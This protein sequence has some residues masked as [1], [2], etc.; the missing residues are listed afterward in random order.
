MAYPKVGPASLEHVAF[1]VQ[2]GRMEE[3]LRFF[4]EALG[5]EVLDESV[6]GARGSWGMARFVR[7]P[8]S[9]VEVQLSEEA[10][11]LP[12]TVDS[13][14]HL[15]IRVIR[16]KQVADR[17]HRYALEQG[18]QSTPPEPGNPEKTLWFLGIPEIFAF[19]F[20]FMPA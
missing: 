10:K 7:V 15:G 3:A 20:E 14:V 1:R 12:I 2:T 9:N 19:E 18:W 17:L 16:P 4:S 8:N 11:K 13:S 5:W 6:R